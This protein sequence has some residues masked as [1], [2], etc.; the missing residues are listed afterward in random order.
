MGG[1]VTYRVF[2]SDREH[3]QVGAHRVTRVAGKSELLRWPWAPLHE[4]MH[5]PSSQLPALDGLR[6]IAVLLVICDHWRSDWIDIAHLPSLPIMKFP[7]FYWGWTGV[8]LFFVL[9]GFL[10]GKQLWAE[11][12]RTG[13]ISISAFVIRRGLRIWPLYY[14]TMIVLTVLNLP[15]APSW[16]DWVMLS[17]YFISHYGRGWSLSTEEQFY[18]LMPTLLLLLNRFVPRKTWPICIA[19]IL[20]LVVVTRYF[21]FRT[22][23]AQGIDHAFISGRLMYAPFHLH[24]EPLLAG[25]LIGWVT[26][27]RPTWLQPG[28]TGTI[29]RRAI[30]IGACVAIVGLALRALQREAFPYF[31]LASV[32]GAAMCIS[33]A[34][35]SILTA[36]LRW[37]VWYPI[38]RLSFGMYLNHLMVPE[39]NA[40]V[41]ALTSGWFSQS[42]SLAFVAGLGISVVLSALTAA[43][44]YVAIEYPGLALRDRILASRREVR[45]PAVSVV[46]RD[47]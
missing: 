5:R 16:S 37:P 29:A 22:F 35:R 10:I 20:P 13:T 23:A 42:P 30:A 45:S 43:I 44:T 7:S 28:E 27:R 18:L 34:D 38:A 4:L 41:I 40:R 3:V 2:E 31:A 21:T 32:Y 26:V 14:A 11:L 36:A 8:D 17:N 24:C 1:P 47:L 9:S 33:L 39:V 19:A 6:A 46:A 25:L 12:Y 15:G